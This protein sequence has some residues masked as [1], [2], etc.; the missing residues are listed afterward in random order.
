LN[1]M[2]RRPF[3]LV[4]LLSLAGAACS[5]GSET[6]L[7]LG[8]SPQATNATTAPL[9]PT[10]R[11][12][13]PPMTPDEFQQ[14]IA[15]LKGTPI[16]VNFWASWCG[17][18]RLEAPGLGAVARQYGGKVQFIGVDLQDI[19]RNAQ[20]TIRDFAYPYPSVAD[21]KQDIKHAYGYFAQ[22]VTIF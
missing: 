3:L 5:G 18:C 16:V 11:F 21:P 6:P 8:N 2:L 4:V 15:Q 7:Q 9:L 14:L 12:D 22:P 13:L 10:G 1:V 17:S 19:K 20:I